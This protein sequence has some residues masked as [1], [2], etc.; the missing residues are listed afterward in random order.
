MIVPGTYQVSETANADY[1]TTATCTSS[2]GHPADDPSSINLDAGETVTCTFTNTKRGH[3]IVDK[4]TSPS[5]DPQNFSF[6]AGGG[7]YAD[8]NLTDAA[9]PNDQ[10]LAPGNYSVSETVP[11]GWD[12]TSSPCVSSI[13]DTETAAALELDAGETITCTFTNTKRGHIIVDKVTNPSGDPQS[14]DFDAGGGNYADFSLTDAAAANDQTLVPG[15]YSVSETVPSGWDLTNSPCVSSIGDTETAAALELDAGETITCTFTNT[16]RGHIIVDKITV[17]SGDPQSFSF[18]AGGG[19][20]AD[21]SLTDA[22]APND[23]SLA[24]GNYSVSETVPAGWDLTS[25]PCV[26]S[27]GDTETAAALD[28][29]AGETITCTFTNTKRGHIIVDKVTTPSGD[30]QSFDF[31]AGGGSYADFSLTDAAAPNDQ[32][33]AP[34]SYSVSE[35]VPAGWDLTSSTCVSNLGDSESPG[36]LELDAGETITC[37]FTNTKRGHIIVDKVTSPSSDPQSFDFDAGG[38]SYADFSLTDGDAPNDQTLVPGNYSVSE[39]VPPGWDLTSSP[40]VSSIGDTETAG[41]LELDS[42]ETITCTFTNTK[43]GHIVVDKVT[44]PS[45]DPQSFSFDAGGGSYADFGLTDADAPNDQTLVPGNYSVSETVPAG[46][47]LTSS[48][49]ISSIGDTETAAALEL[50]AGETITCTFTNTKRGHIVVDK[51]TSPSGDPQSFSFDANGG[52]YADFSL[53]DAAAANDQTLVPGNYSV[54]ESVPSGWDLTTSPCVSSIGDTETAAA[55]ELDAGE[56]ITCTFNNRKRATLIVEKQTDPDG[57]SGSFTFTGTA[58]GTISDGGNIP[59]GNL[60][61]GT[62]TST[63]NNPAPNFDLTAIVCNDGNSTGD[64]PSR[65][66]TFRLE[67]GETVTCTFTN[68]QRGMAQVVKTVSGLPPAAGQNFTFEL[69][70]G[71]STSSDGTVI[72]S[73]NTDASGI[74]NFTTKLIPG[75]TYQI[76]EWVFPG[77]N[78]NLVGDGPL[79]VP[80]SIIPPALPNPNVN[81]LTV[82][83]DFTVQP[84]QTRT[85]TVNNTPPPGGRALTIGFWKNWASCSNSNGKGQKPMLDLALGFASATTTNPPGGLVVSAQNPGSLWPNYAAAWYLVL[86]G[87][88]TSTANN[89]KPAPDCTKAVNLLNKS[90]IDGKK[91]QSSDPLFN[92][93]AQLLAAELNRFMGAGINGTT[94]MNIDRAVLLNG[95][96]KFNGLTYSPKLTTADT[97]TANC[98]ATQLDNY[99]NGRPVS[100]CP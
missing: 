93:T 18:D 46:W 97:N 29:D 86:K 27:V 49:C 23:Q 63:E 78:T 10:T 7:S 8:F 88:P 67:P 83:A 94:I 55:L 95:K 51:V 75:D 64:V 37:T 66:A 91:K 48:P 50:D 13:G 90:T 26:S 35:T 57:A 74:I 38:G 19:S 14:F 6:D 77:W 99:N 89:I 11:A 82:C 30:P 59:V 71:A 16:K 22:D 87:D 24:P 96:Y 56:T 44:S 47:D 21:F 34:G 36:A 58:A 20:Y 54:S 68:T 31:D 43:R 41:S 65:T 84:G 4:V 2:L 12:L 61:P 72:E 15:N 85:F 98:L 28:L 60:V 40:C 73:K 45:G 53:T 69:R 80:S 52:S 9:A 5:G 33:L 3:I 92:L 42:G 76:C 81:N 70:Q 32:S 17:P 100:L 79:F 1:V 39:T 62:Y 25:S